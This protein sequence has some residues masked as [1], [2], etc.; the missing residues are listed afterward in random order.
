MFPKGASVTV[1]KLFRSI[2]VT[3]YVLKKSRAERTLLKETAQNKT[4]TF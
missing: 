4:I 1:K 3:L 2:K